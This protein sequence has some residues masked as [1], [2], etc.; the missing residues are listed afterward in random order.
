MRKYLLGKE[1]GFYKAN[2]HCHT[3]ISDGK[4]TPEEVKEMYKNAGYS[5]VAYTDHDV[6]V[7]H[8]ELCDDSF[9]ALNGLEVAV[10]PI[11]VSPTPISSKTCHMCM[12]ALKQDNK[13]QPLFNEKYVHIGNSRNYIPLVKHSDTEPPYE[14]KYTGE[15]I[16]EIM[17][18]YRDAGFFVTYNHPTWSQE[19]YPEYINYFGMHAMEMFNGSCLM[20]GYD[21]YNHRVYDDMIKSGKHIFCI[22]ADDNHNK[23]TLPD[24][25]RAFT[26]INAK[27]LTYDEITAA[28]LR[29]DFYAT[30][31]P[32]IHE[33]YYEDGKIHLECTPAR[34]IT[35]NC[36]TRRCRHI[37]SENGEPITS[38]DIDIPDDAISFRVTVTDSAGYHATTSAYFIDSLK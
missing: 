32:E 12:I 7:P 16:S 36:L 26:M 14:Y 28:L 23:P 11:L 1:G 15:G 19:S 17:Q 20:L 31:A 4:K 25:V 34:E 33:L 38:V 9:I 2:L 22:G 21:E 3:T 30:E 24:S 27:A 6:L 8:D 13:T 35:V 18:G 37:W 5:V 10:K 29:G